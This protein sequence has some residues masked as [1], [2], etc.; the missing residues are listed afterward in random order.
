MAL[1]GRAEDL[2]C[3]AESVPGNPYGIIDSRKRASAESLNGECAA[4]LLWR[5]DQIE[6]VTKEQEQ[7][8]SSPL[9]R[10]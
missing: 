3:D 1:S 8:E 2:R 4:R 10:E 9:V 5:R 7:C 6:V